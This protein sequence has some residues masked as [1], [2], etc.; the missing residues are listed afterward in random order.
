MIFA[1]DDFEVDDRLF[2]LRR[3]GAPVRLEPRVFDLLLHL[4]RHP[5]RVVPRSELRAEVWQGVAVSDSAI[6]TA[7][8]ALRKALGAGRDGAPI[9]T[10]YGRG[11]RF[12]APVAV[13]PEAAEPGAHTATGQAAALAAGEDLFVGRGAVMATLC[14][15]L[16][17][18]RGGAGR[19]ALLL[20][21]PGIGKTRT[22]ERLGEEARAQGVA[23]A[24]GR[25]PEAE[26]AP[27]YW[28]WARALRP[29]LA[30]TDPPGEK[31]RGLDVPALAAV[32]PELA[33]APGA[34]GAPAGEMHRFRVFDAVAEW[35]ARL[36]VEAPLFVWID[37][38]HWADEA[39]QELFAWLARE[40]GELPVL[41]LATARSDEAA[42]GSALAR[43]LGELA[44]VDRVERID[45]AGFDEDEVAEYLARAAG[46][47]PPALARVLRERTEGNPF[48]LRETVRLLA[49]EGAL[50][51]GDSAER[52]R[53]RLPPAVRD[54]VRR[55]LAALRPECVAALRLAA[56]IG[57]DF[58]IATWAAADGRPREAF[59]E[60]LDRAVAARILAEPAG[61]TGRL[62]F[63]H[64]LV[65]EALLDDRA[66][67]ERAALHERVAAALLALHGDGPDAPAAEIARHLHAAAPR[68]HG[69]AA[70]DW[71][72]RAARAAGARGA[73]EEAALH[74]A[75]ALDAL[76]LAP[77]ATAERRL[78]LLLLRGDAHV[79][80]G[81]VAATRE[82]FASAAAL[83]R[84]LG[85]SAD[86]V[87]AA[88]GYGGS[89]LWGNRP[90]ASDRALLE[91]A[92]RFADDGPAAQRAM[93]A[94]RLVATRGVWGPLEPERP[95]SE[96]ALALARASG[97][98]EALSEALHARHFVLQGP[99]HLE[100]REAL[101]LEILAIGEALG[102]LDRTFAI[103][104]VRAADSLIR[105][106]RAGFAAM[107]DEAHRAARASHHPA[108]L[109]LARSAAASAALLEGRFADAERALE[110]AAEHGRRA[111]SPQALPLAIGQTLAL[112]RAQG[113]LGEVLP[114][115]ERVARDLDWLGSF[116]RVMLATIHAELGAHERARAVLDELAP[117]LATLPRR[118][119]W[120]V[121]MTE[122]AFVC[123]ATGD[124]ARAAV[125]HEQ[126]APHARLHSVYP[127][128][129]LY[130]GPVAHALGVLA[131]ALGR[132]G[133]AAARL[134]A[135]LGAAEAVSAAPAR[136]RIACD[137]GALLLAS[138][139]AG[140]RERGRALVSEALE[141]AEALGMPPLAERAAGLL[142]AVPGAAPRS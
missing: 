103:R 102:R 93:L 94:A 78:A 39:S 108:F 18:A 59:L 97:D 4:V 92:V 15:A 30:R 11:Y 3:A 129:M 116:P 46:P 42:P 37:D 77:A 40:L 76:P 88:L 96:V 83:A 127:G 118:A 115:Y 69:D 29:L 106:D 10:L 138:A 81:D 13:R 32:L 43:T 23:T 45:L 105:G 73:Y 74:A 87:R 52:L 125:L 75:R 135:A 5:D 51:A 12:T 122:L 63:A 48:F 132:P 82:A 95:A 62:R 2:Q 123:A 142:G 133:E 64:A 16:A 9:Q 72:E 121:A 70:L 22:A 33:G 128:P 85:R 53:A 107:L 8:N 26:G 130:A 120:L 119:D 98:P 38:L 36:A 34:P 28:P 65:R 80:S 114:L 27:P 1:F 124:R 44:R 54:A 112:R 126:L 71:A 111:R 104:E 90:D 55:R 41:L 17:A 113:R 117:R 89:A 140:E 137:L 31:L 66:P 67:G 7:V 21:E 50:A 60:D 79:R 19:V 141:R 99:D 91:D 109:W 24:A 49:A 139:R 136:A 68:G 131:A 86:F 58:A 56:A 20:G 6:P 110:E 134:E 47:A 14:A 61:Q 35:L 25:C 100:E 101:A 84:E 57:R